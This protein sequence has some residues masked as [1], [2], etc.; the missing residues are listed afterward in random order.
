MKTVTV[1]AFVNSHH[2]N[3]DDECS[4]TIRVTHDRIKRYYPTGIL[5]KAA[6]FDRV[7]KAKRRNEAD[8]KLFK[9]IH[10]HED[11][12][13]KAADKIPI[14]TFAKF[15]EIYLDNKEASDRI[16]HAFDAYAQELRVENRIGTA[17]S[18]D[19]AKASLEAFK[20]GL[21]FADVTP[22]LL[23]R[24]EAWMIQK[25]KSK[26][27]VGI[28]LRSLRTIFNRAKVDNAL[29]PFGKNK[30]IIPTGRNVK[31]A[32]TL[33][34]I[35]RIFNYQPMQGS[36]EEMARDYWIFI[37][38]CNGLNVKDLC[39]LKRKDIDGEILTYERAKTQLSERH[40][41]K[42]VV[43]LKPRAKKVISTWGQPSINP[44][45]FIFPHLQAG[46]SPTK[47]RSTYQQL[48]KTINKYMKRIAKKVEISKPVTTY[49]A[50]HSFA[51]IL[52]RSGA[53]MEFISEALGH[54]D[55]KTTRNYL[56]GFEAETIHRTTD[57]LTAFANE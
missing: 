52:K 34:E 28:Y 27:T 49:F 15:E 6:D 44:N 25:G 56:A 32:L 21:R 7:M 36:T 45:S 4:V 20:S 16:A 43:S 8:N 18:Y 2:P 50:R 35:G 47:E 42:I 17:V 9:K 46:M 54:S 38:L 22:S 13:L 37:Y 24:Y 12:A 48:T 51:T 3:Q 23:K 1:K 33:D 31:K 40:S 19:V 53:S 26:T 41:E 29:Y 39:F 10:A 57:A 5:M 30:Y 11:K 14:F 55:L